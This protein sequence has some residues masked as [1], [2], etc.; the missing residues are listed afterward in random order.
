MPWGEKKPLYIWKKN[1]N[2][3]NNIKDYIYFFVLKQQ[4]NEVEHILNLARVL[5]NM[6]K[7]DE[8]QQKLICLKTSKDRR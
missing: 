6:V 8:N 4:K 7:I 2:S 1:N 3:G 5:W